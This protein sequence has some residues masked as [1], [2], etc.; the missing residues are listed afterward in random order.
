MKKPFN[1][2][3]TFETGFTVA[4]LFWLLLPI[5]AIDFSQVLAVELKGK[6][7]CVCVC[8][9]VYLL[10]PLLL[11]PSVFPGGDKIGLDADDD[12]AC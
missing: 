4:V 12:D 7:R 9:C 1:A 5:F 2:P 11:R 6:L 3:K 10:V 8:V